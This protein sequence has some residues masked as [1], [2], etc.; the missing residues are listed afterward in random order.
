MFAA[1]NPEVNENEKDN[2]DFFW[3]DRTIDQLMQFD[4]NNS[5]K[6]DAVMAM[7]H[8]EL[9]SQSLK[10][11]TPTVQTIKSENGKSPIDYLF[12]IRSGNNVLTHEQYFKNKNGN[13]QQFAG[14]L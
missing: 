2:L 7:I 14:R 13:R 12:P 3:F 1:P 6:Y 5:T 8:T 4:K 11:Y 10:K 9:G